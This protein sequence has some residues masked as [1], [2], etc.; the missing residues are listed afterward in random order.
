MSST[1]ESDN[2]VQLENPYL[3]DKEFLYH[4]FIST[5]VNLPQRFGDVKVSMKH[6]FLYV[7]GKGDLFKC[8]ALN[9]FGYSNEKVYIIFSSEQ[10]FFFRKMFNIVLCLQNMFS[11]HTLVV[12]SNLIQRGQPYCIFQVS[13]S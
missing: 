6:Q 1:G 7:V 4:L 10:F 3:T 11:V 9:T 13:Q 2:K 8:I 5:S 12:T